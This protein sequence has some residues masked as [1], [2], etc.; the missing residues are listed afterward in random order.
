MGYGARTRRVRAAAAAAGAV[1]AVGALLG[2]CSDGG[3]S[4]AQGRPA[5]TFTPRP[6]P[7]PAAGGHGAGPPLDAAR[8]PRTAAQA[9]ALAGRI[10][11]DPGLFGR[12]VRRDSPYESDPAAWPVLDGSCVWRIRPVPPDVLAS[13]TRYYR[14]PAGPGRSG[15]RLTAT[16]TVHRTPRDSSW[17]IARAM[18]EVMRCPAQELRD[19]ERL[20][21]LFTSALHLSEQN[22]DWAQEAFSETG[23][24]HDRT[25]GPYP[26]IWAEGKYGP[27]TVAVSVRGAQGVTRAALVGLV[28]EGQTWMM[29]RAQQAIGRAS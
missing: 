4:G 18:E 28:A 24:F 8:V 23:D 10:V 6:L 25:G 15:T 16:V 2:A 26:Y 22:N 19:G 20:D 21:S 9:R 7:S 1:G 3:G 27:V 14:V 12:E 29:R 17:E 13:V 11:A 5:G